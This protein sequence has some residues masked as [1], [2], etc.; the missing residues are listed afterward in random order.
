[1][2]VRRDMPLLIAIV[3]GP[4]C[5]GEPGVPRAEHDALLQRLDAMDQRLDALEE[6]RA[7][8]PAEGEAP[9]R[10]FADAFVQPYAAA[11]VEGALQPTLK[12]RVTAGGVEI[13][14]TLVAQADV[15]ARFR[16]VALMAPHTRLMVLTEPDVPY[17]AVVDALD[18]AREA[19]LTDI[20]MSAR[21]HGEGE[22]A[23]TAGL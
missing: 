15:L 5:G 18:L 9:P 8:R 23:I 10:P 4:S 2:G 20:A 12:V 21:I 22:G 19:G 3:L 14:G 7:G 1:V 17:S 16:E 6:A 11:A 13:D